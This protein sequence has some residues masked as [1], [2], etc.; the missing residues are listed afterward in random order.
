MTYHNNAK[1]ANDDNAK[2]LQIGT[3]NVCGLKYCYKC[4]STPDI[5]KPGF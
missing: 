1:H 4:F 5:D 2:Q 3:A